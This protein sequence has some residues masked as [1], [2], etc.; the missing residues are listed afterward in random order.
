VSEFRRS[1]A[2]QQ[3]GQLEMIQLLNCIFVLFTES[4]NAIRPRW[5]SV[6]ITFACLKAPD[7]SAQSPEAVRE[8]IKG[9]YQVG[10][11]LITAADQ[12]ILSHS[13]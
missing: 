6:F 3:M 12:M 10:L 1:T 2:F 9:L 11:K 8:F 13:R 7:Y 5:R 4:I